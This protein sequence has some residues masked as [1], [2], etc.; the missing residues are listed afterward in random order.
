V[1]TGKPASSFELGLKLESLTR[2]PMP[3]AVRTQTDWHFDFA[4]STGLN[5]QPS[6]ATFTSIFNNAQGTLGE[7]GFLAMTGFRSPPTED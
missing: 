3:P 2:S 5:P 1:K 6:K 4:F 7:L